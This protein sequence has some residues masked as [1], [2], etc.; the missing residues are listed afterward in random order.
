[1]KTKETCSICGKEFEDNYKDKNKFNKRIWCNDCID[2]L[3]EEKQNEKQKT[4]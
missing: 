2:K 1:M 3:W 4:I